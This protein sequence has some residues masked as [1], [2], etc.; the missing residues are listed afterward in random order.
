MSFYLINLNFSHINWRV[1]PLCHSTFAVQRVIM[2]V[3]MSQSRPL[4]HL[5][6]R[7]I[8]LRGRF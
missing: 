5:E 8:N 2:D 1:S 4:M 3:T 6:I 7:Y